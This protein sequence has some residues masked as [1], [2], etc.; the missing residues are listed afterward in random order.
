MSFVIWDKSEFQ[1][2]IKF[3]Y[4]KIIE[5]AVSKEINQVFVSIKSFRQCLL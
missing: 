1:H 4:D 5:T 3:R 2:L